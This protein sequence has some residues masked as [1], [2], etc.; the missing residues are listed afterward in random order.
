MAEMMRCWFCG[1]R[2]PPP[3]TGQLSHGHTQLDALAAH[4]MRCPAHA[5]AP[6]VEAA[7]QLV[8]AQ[9][10]GHTHEARDAVATIRRELS[11]H[12][13]LPDAWEQRSEAQRAAENRRPKPNEAKRPSRRRKKV[14]R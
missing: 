13:L 7:R 10:A 12:V 14:L 11:T 9:D 6:L 2:I 8:T 5:V 1:E 4:V 3:E